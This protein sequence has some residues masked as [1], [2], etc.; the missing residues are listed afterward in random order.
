MFSQL[1]AAVLS[2]RP[3][4][5]ADMLLLSCSDKMVRLAE[6][7]QRPADAQPV[8]KKDAEATIS[9]LGVGSIP[10]TGYSTS[11]NGLATGVGPIGVCIV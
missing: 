1:P 10:E 7:Q 4:G 11:R 6:V 5:Q 9:T 8:S 2:M 3:A